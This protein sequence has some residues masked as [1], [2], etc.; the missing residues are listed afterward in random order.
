MTSYIVYC[1]KNKLNNKKYIGVTS[2]TP[3]ARWQNGKHYSRHKK[4]Y[5][6][7][8]K[9]GWDNFSHEVLYTDLTED[10]AKEKEIELIEKWDLIN[11]G[12]NTL[13]G[14]TIPKH[15]EA[16][17]K[18]LQELN[19][20][21]NNPFYKRKHTETS[22]KLMSKNRPKKGVICVDTGVYYEST[23]EAQRQTGTDHGDISKCCK[24][25]KKT[26]GGFRWKYA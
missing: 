15:N 4:L 12:Y 23:R 17:I 16:T 8:L 14:G 9:Y 7:I 26:A 6:D 3:C 21:E 20:R 11:K 2:Q 25:N 1:L 13:R 10:E 24:G 5:N 18:K 22:K 19:K